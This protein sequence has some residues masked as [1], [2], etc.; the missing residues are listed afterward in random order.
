MVNAFN[1][2]FKDNKYGQKALVLA[3]IT[4]LTQ[5]CYNTADMYKGCCSNVPPSAEYYI[6]NILGTLIHM[7]AIGYG[8]ACIKALFEQN[9]NY[10]L[11]F[12]NLKNS[13]ILGLKNYIAIFL[14]TTI[15]AI[16]TLIPVFIGYIIKTVPVV[17][18]IITFIILAATLIYIILY[19][20]AYAWI[21][22]KTGSLTSY[23]RIRQATRL[24][25]EN[26]GS[27]WKAIGLFVLL[28]II[29]A[30]PY[31]A[32]TSICMAFVTNKIA[33]IAIISLVAAAIT[34]YTSFA[35]FFITAK[36]INPETAENI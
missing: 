21:F 22:A 34:A 2:M 14:F 6:L 25:K 19:T 8:F 4:L 35:G 18:L 36:A 28:I 17:P 3:L 13:F 27:Y 12:I 32:T 7:F 1:Y 10:V 5:L 9:D 15:L 16:I 30:I 26:K 24:I 29:F 31:V 20:M 11:P 23:L 33:Y